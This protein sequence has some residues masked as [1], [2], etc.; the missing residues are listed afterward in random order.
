M[1]AQQQFLPRPV[2]R[3][4][5]PRL[6]SEGM[7]GEGEGAFIVYDLDDAFNVVIATASR[8]NKLLALSDCTALF[9]AEGVF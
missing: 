2:Q 6:R 7:K 1:R 9:L 5:P 8:K 4:S 3:Q